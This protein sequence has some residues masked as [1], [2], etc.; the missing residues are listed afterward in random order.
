MATTNG[1]KGA[2]NFGKVVQIIGPVVDIE[3]SDSNLPSIYQ[4]LRI[5]SEGFDVPR[6]ID[7]ICEVQQHLGEGRVRTVSMLPTDGM[8]RGMRAVDTG[9][10]ITVPVGNG[11][12]GRI[13]NV[14]GEPVDER[15]PVDAATRYAIHRHAPTFE[16][17]STELEM[18]ITG[19]KVIDLIQPFLKGG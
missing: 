5:T 16:D 15:G 13:I 19:I 3:F 11:T 1:A 2:G 9:G 10:P 8:I 7:V 6:P 4:A 14:I 12:L 18:L 17:Q